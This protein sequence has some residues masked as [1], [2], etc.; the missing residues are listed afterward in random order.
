MAIASA[1]I[2]IA[3]RIPEVMEPWSR[4]SVDPRMRPHDRDVMRC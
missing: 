4:A 1:P 3:N 2:A